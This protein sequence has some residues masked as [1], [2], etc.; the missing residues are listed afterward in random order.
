V[1]TGKNLEATFL[2]HPA[3]HKWRRGSVVR[4]PVVGAGGFSLIC[5]WQLT[6]LWVNCPLW[7]SQLGQYQFWELIFDKLSSLQ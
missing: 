2:P 6:T 7:V 5:G 1:K 3:A 4:T